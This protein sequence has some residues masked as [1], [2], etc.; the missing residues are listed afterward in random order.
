MPRT[1]KLSTYRT[2]WAQKGDD[3]TVTYASTVVVRASGDTVTLDSGGWRTV[4]TKRKMNQASNQFALRFGVH[5]RKGQWYVDIK[6]P[7]YGGD[8]LAPYG[9]GLNIPFEDGMTFNIYTGQ[10]YAPAR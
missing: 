4:T 1:D 5:Q 3:V 9:Q 2:T 7:K 8:A 10:V 6:S